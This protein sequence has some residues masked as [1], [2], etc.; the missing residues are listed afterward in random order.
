MKQLSKGRKSK[1]THAQKNK[2]SRAKRKERRKR[3]RKLM[4]GEIMTLT[5]KEVLMM[6]RERLGQIIVLSH[7]L[8]EYNI[9]HESYVNEK[10]DSM[11]SIDKGNQEVFDLMADAIAFHYGVI[12]TYTL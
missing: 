9:P 12:I 8:S 2:D 11:P 3:Q 7:H 6:V 4:K 10:K 5:R 1:K